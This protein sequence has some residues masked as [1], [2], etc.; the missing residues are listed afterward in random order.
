MKMEPS[1]RT[2]WKVERCDLGLVSPAWSI[3][4]FWVLDGEGFVDM[5][6]VRVVR[7]VETLNMP[8]TGGPCRQPLPPR[9]EYEAR[10][11][12]LQFR[13]TSV[14]CLREGACSTAT[15]RELWTPIGSG[16]P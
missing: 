9:R 10:W 14:P 5:P 11:R 13:R 3:D 4:N 15:G 16:R 2:A 6:H 7:S 12:A 8:G 1:E